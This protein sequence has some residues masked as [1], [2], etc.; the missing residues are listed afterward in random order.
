MILAGGAQQLLDAEVGTLALST[1]L[2]D[3]FNLNVLLKRATEKVSL[4]AA[5]AIGC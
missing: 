1:I 2:V 5:Y 3:T 4:C